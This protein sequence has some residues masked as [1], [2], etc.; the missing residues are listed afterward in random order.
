[1]ALASLVA[2][3]EAF[4]PSTRSFHT[5]RAQDQIVRQSTTPEVVESAKTA[6]D[7]SELEALTADIVSKLRFREVQRELERREVDTTGTFTTM[8]TRLMELAD[9]ANNGEQN[10][11]G[12]HDVHVISNDALNT[13]SLDL[14]M[15]FIVREF[16]KYSLVSDIFPDSH[17]VPFLPRHSKIREYHSKII[18]IQISI[19]TIC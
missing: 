4:Q 10:T 19:S 16:F 2:P 5:A 9:D 8:R 18:R 12:S 13:V 14:A 7:D 1:M 15:A 11:E 6:G 3:T 17:P